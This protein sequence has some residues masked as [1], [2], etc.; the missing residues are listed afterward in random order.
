[1]YAGGFSIPQTPFPND[2]REKQHQ[3]K[4]GSACGVGMWCRYVVF[5]VSNI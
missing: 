2:R 1:M 4:S 3:M 5:N